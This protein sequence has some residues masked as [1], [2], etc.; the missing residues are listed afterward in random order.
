MDGTRSFGDPTNES[1][2]FVDWRMN[3]NGSQDP[4]YDL[5]MA[6][7]ADVLVDTAYLPFCLTQ[8]AS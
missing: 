1:E 7:A 8:L 6:F 4:F 2:L 5:D 3:G